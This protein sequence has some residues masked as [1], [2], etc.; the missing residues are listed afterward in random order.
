MDMTI[1]D[2]QVAELLAKKV[3]EKILPLVTKYIDKRLD[4]VLDD[5]DV[6]TA[7]YVYRNILNCTPK[8][9]EWYLQQPG[10]PTMKKVSRVAFSRKA[11][12]RWIANNQ[13]YA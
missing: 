9:F 10:F 2:N 1:D 6:V 13:Q 3:A 8:T 5:D 7:E 4:E 11:V 12:N